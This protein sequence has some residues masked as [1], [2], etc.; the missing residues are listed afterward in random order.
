MHA[1]TVVNVTET[2][3]GAWDK[4]SDGGQTGCRTDTQTNRKHGTFAVALHT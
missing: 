4:K 3:T 1:G 2:G